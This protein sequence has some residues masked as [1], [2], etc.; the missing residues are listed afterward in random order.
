MWVQIPLRPTSPKVIA[1][2]NYWNY[3]SQHCSINLNNN[4]KT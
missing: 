4:M 2:Q 1:K 3:L